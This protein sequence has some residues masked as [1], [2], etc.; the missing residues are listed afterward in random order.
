MTNMSE[1]LQ[2]LLI[3]CPVLC[4]LL[5]LTA[6]PWLAAL[7]WRVARTWLRRPVNWGYL[8]AGGVGAGLAAAFVLEGSTAESGLAAVGRV[9]TALLQL[10][11]T[12]DLF[13]AV[14]A[15]LLW[16]WPRGAAVALASF[17]EGVRQPMFW[18]LT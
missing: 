4:V 17:R 16:L 14:F 12:A 18:L 2:Q 11:L 1:S 13:V 8:L 10:Q 7:D 5:V 15:L 6:V 9:Y 3:A